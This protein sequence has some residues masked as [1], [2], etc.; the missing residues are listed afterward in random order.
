MFYF[1][2][3]L[4]EHIL[5]LSSLVWLPSV[6]TKRA[7][8]WLTENVGPQDISDIVDH[9]VV[10]FPRRCASYVRPQ[11]QFRTIQVVLHTV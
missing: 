9:T 7:L 10:I 1:N 4:V 5:S 3:F 11:T 8:L 6:E 2:T